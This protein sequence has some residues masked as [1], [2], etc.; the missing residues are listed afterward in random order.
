[1]PIS[2]VSASLLPNVAATAE[3][4]TGLRV[5]QDRVVRVDG[6]LGFGVATF[7]GVPVVGQPRTGPDVTVHRDSPPGERARHP[8][9]PCH[10]G[11]HLAARDSGKRRC[12]R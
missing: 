8:R 9:L 10:Y 2:G 7:G 6:V 5:V 1:M 12:A 11:R 3:A 4:L